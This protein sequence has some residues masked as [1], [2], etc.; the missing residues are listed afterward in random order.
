MLEE[1]LVSNGRT[2]MERIGRSVGVHDGAFHADEV[3]ACAL[4]VL[5]SLVDAS[6]IIRTRDPE[7]LACCE[8]VCDVGGIYAPERK[9]FDH[10]QSDYQGPLSSAGMVLLYLRDQGIISAEVY[11]F[12]N[13]SLV[14]GVDA[15]DNGHAIQEIGCT[16]FSHIIANFAPISYEVSDEQLNN[17]FIEAFRFAYGHL[18]RLQARYLYNVDCRTVIGEEMKKNRHFLLFERA[19]PWFESFFA[20]GG[21]NHP[22]LFLIMP[23][24]SHWKLRAIPPDYDHRMDL[25]LA[26]PKEWA[27]LLEEELRAVSGIEGAIFCHK[28]RFTSVWQTRDD[29]FKALQKVFEKN[30]IQEKVAL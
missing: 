11:D 13:N 25:R 26:L 8:Y 29:A 21:I 4:L 27:G 23:A 10:H 16:S 17:A 24:G 30:G 9:L 20:L 3:T 19:L 2:S 12:Y 15:H 22:A 5:F 28:G 1:S 7:R 18:S 14:R 6:K